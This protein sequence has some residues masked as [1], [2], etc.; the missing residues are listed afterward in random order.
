M[1]VKGSVE[2]YFNN[3][4]QI[5]G[6]VDSSF[7]DIKVTVTNISDAIKKLSCNK[8][9]GADNIYT[10]QLKY[11]SAKIFPLLSMYLTSFFVH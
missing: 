11:P 9:C 2:L 3:T 7:D 5:M 10:E 8:S 4:S 1:I 6:N